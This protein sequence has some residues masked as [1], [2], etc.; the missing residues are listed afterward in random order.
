M[1]HRL[2]AV[3]LLLTWSGQAAPGEPLRLPPPGDPGWEPVE[4]P[5]VERPT[6]YEAI[7][8]EGRPGGRALRAEAECSASARVLQL[9]E[10]LDLEATPLLRWSW[11]A[12][13]VSVEVPDERSKPGD[14]F[15]ARVGVMFPFE[16]ERAGWL[17]RV[18]NGIAASLAGREVPGTTLYFVWSA[19]AEPGSRWKSPYGEEIEVVVLERGETREWR[20]AAVDLRRA[21]RDAFGRNPPR[22][23]AVGLM[24]DSD[25]HCGEARADYGTLEFSEAP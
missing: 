11:R 19:H 7:A 18:R 12:I 14:D 17:A 20:D 6:D 23:V 13:R 9:P 24:S 15:A 2:I 4:L 16:P 1:R 22:P 5:G 10:T 3:A 25:N 8:V 21:Y